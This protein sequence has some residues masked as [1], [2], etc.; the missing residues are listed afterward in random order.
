M[1][2]TRDRAPPEGLLQDGSKTM[3]IDG[4][5][6]TIKMTI[7]TYHL[8]AH[9]DRKQLDMLVSRVKG[10]KNVFIMHGEINKLNEFKSD[11]SKKYNAV[12][13]KMGTEY[14]V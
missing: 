13:P 9:A 5:D 2:D 4:K 3:E 1:S 8:S 14:T 6:V 11:L 7:E 10:L 12:I